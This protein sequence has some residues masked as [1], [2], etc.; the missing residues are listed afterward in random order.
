MT[1]R[2]AG[3][4]S[5]PDFGYDTARL[6]QDVLEVMDAMGFER[7]LLVGHS[8]A[9]DELTWLGGHHP[10]RVSGLVYLDAA[11]DRS[12]DRAAPDAVRMR[13]LNRGLPPEPP[14]PPESQ[15]NFDAMTR[16]LLERGH[17]RLPEGELIA[18]HRMNDPYFAGVPNIEARTQQAI[19]AA[20]QPPDYAALKVP[21][22]AIYAI[23]D[24]NAPLP[25]WYDPNDHELMAV[26]AERSRLRDAMQRKSIELF[27]R[28]VENGQVLEMQNARHFIIQS[29]QPEVLEA[30]E[31]FA[32][33]LGL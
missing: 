22:L 10:S 17:A 24:P 5:K 21:A 19:E 1:R 30:I 18:F 16:M 14:R 28:N 13:E 6:G 33:G 15:L 2:G 11:Y 23:N 31:K 8:I 29:N 9:G 32:A 12:G 26:L 7:V 25:S 27:Q 20:L 4:S 3:Y